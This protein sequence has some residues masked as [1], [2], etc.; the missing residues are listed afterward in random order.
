MW[1]ALFTCLMVLIAAPASAQ[2]TPAGDALA[3]L[4]DPW[5]MA[6]QLCSRAE[7]MV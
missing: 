3:M 1:M 4:R 6:I 5:G 2:T 7:P